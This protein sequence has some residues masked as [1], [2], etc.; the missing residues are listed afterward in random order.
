MNCPKCEG[1]TT[2]I[3]SRTIDEYVARKRQCKVCGYKFYTEEVEVE[4]SEAMRKYLRSRY[5]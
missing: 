2:V 5:K 4:E 3:D 1:K